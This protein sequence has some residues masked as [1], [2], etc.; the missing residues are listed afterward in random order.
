MD[1]DLSTFDWPDLAP[2]A[3]AL[4]ATGV[5]VTSLADFDEVVKAIADRDRPVLIDIHLD[6]ADIPFDT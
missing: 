5:T 2:V 4:G 6:P 3:A 1:P